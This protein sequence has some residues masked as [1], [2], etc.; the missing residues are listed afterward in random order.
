MGPMV[1]ED[2]ELKRLLATIAL[3]LAALSTQTPGQPR[4]G[5]FRIHGDRGAREYSALLPT[6]TTEPDFHRPERW[7]PLSLAG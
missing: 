4:L 5:L 6:G 7:L 2:P 3:P 1:C